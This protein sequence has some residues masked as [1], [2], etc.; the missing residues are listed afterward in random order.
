M[1]ETTRQDELRVLF[2]GG[3]TGGHMMPGAATAEAVGELHPDAR[4]LFLC[5][6][7]PSE[8]HC[9]NAV[10]RFETACV[11]QTPIH[12]RLDK[13]AFP[14]RAGAAAQKCLHVFRRLRPHV[15]VGLGSYNSAVPVLTARWM[16]I[17]TA[18]LEANAVPGRAVRA[19]A[20]V[21]DVTF[22]H[23]REA[24]ARLRAKRIVVSGLPIR[25]NVLAGD[26]RRARRRLGLQTDLPL[27]L[28]MGGSQG[29]LAL[30]RTLFGALRLM[31]R[32]GVRLQTLHLT[33]VSHLAEARRAG[34]A[35]SMPYRPVGF[36]DSMGDAYA[37]ADFVLARSGSTVAELAALG[38][39]SVLVPYPYAAH[40]HQRANARLLA[41]D[42][43]AILIDEDELDEPRL[44]DALSAL[45]TDAGLRRRLGEQIRRRGRPRAA[46]RVAAQLA[47]LAGFAAT[48]DRTMRTHRLQA[49]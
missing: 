9:L 25:S 20:P 8:R 39:P 44:A 22:V 42:C 10:A 7:R 23:W 46:R 5:S 48:P 13:L 19:L 35:E 38:M 33:G 47:D 28:A 29:A 41:Q 30:N 31:A 21:A 49:A 3:T 1:T 24:A 15:V 34:P 32:K 16:G 6:K 18:L 36:M 4:C 27:L 11:P 45:A 40:D 14:A 2:A 17:P 26:R 43:A 37:A 12:G